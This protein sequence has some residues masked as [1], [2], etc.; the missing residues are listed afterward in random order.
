M[1][2]DSSTEN[3]YIPLMSK[4]SVMPNRILSL[5]DLEVQMTA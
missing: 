5:G 4:L 1:L 2:G 3:V